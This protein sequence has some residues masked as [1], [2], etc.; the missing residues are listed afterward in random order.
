MRDSR[1]AILA[2]GGAAAAALAGWSLWEA[3]WVERRRADV[4]IPGLAPPLEGLK[5]LHL[6]DLHLGTLSLNGRALE[7]AVRWAEEVRPDLVAV[8]GDLVTRRGGKERLLEA[9]TRLGAAHGVFAV[10]GNHDVDYSRDPFRRPT[11]LSDLHEAGAVLLRD[12]ERTL[13]R[14]QARIQVVGVSPETFRFGGAR[15][16]ERADARADLR[17]LICHYPNVVWTLPQGAFHLVLAGHYHGGQICI[18]SPWGKLRLKD[19]RANYWEGLFETQAGALHVS[20]GLGTSLV[21]FRLLARPEATL[22]TL[23]GGQ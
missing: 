8:S 10:L 9:L 1:A 5:I 12:D 22:L 2:A 19:L 21:P 20:R 7:Q 14:G 17:I 13:R 16:A 11:D 3:Q 18:P 23:R 6:S 15:P 4:W